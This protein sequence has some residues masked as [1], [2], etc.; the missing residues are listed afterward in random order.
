M[1]ALFSDRLWGLK[2]ALAV[3]AFAVLGHHA[4][5]RMRER[6]PHIAGVSVYGDSL[7]GK[8]VSVQALTVVGHAPDG[9]DLD[10]SVG[11]MRIVS[12][13]RPPVGEAVSVVG[14]VLGNRRIEAV[15]IQANEGWAW[16][17]PLNYS[18]SVATLLVFLWL[19]RDRFR[20]RLADGLFR[21]R[22]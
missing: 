13:G 3:A 2:L 15:R 1:K 20:L 17:R 19:V 10:T 5:G 22:C 14:R 7:R 21:S 12:D 11:P 18:V 4:R 9:F 6:Y 8:T 16:K